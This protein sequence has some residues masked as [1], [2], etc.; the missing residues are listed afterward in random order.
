MTPINP[1]IYKRPEELLQNLI[2][3]NTT[4]PPG[5]EAPLMGYID[6]LLTA[7][8]FE[9]NFLSKD[10]ARPNLITRLK[11]KGEAP[12]LLLYGHADVVTTANMKW[13]YPPFEG[14]IAD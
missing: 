1:S 8:G 4:N 3:F 6:T 14:T 5:N 13:T 9:A 11:G 12:P 2:R 10:H 7:A